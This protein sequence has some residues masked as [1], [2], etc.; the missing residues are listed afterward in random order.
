MLPSKKGRERTLDHRRPTRKRS[1]KIRIPP[2]SSSKYLK[3]LGLQTKF[4]K[5]PQP[6]VAHAVIFPLLVLVLV[7]RHV[8]GRV[9]YREIGIDAFVRR[10]LWQQVILVPV[11]DCV[12]IVRIDL[13]SH[14]VVRLLALLSVIDNVES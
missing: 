14:S 1:A 4:G 2:R 11:T 12:C 3:T 9:R 8:I 10:K 6:I 13:D 7:D 5:I